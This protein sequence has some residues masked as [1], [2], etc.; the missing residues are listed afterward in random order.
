MSHLLFLTD[1]FHIPVHGLLPSVRYWELQPLPARAPCAVEEAGERCLRGFI[2][3]SLSMDMQWNFPCPSWISIQTEVCWASSAFRCCSLG[4][5]P[6]QHLEE[7][8]PKQ[9]LPRFE[10]FG[11]V[12]F[13]FS[14]SNLPGS[15]LP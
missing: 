2:R 10:V 11:K 8:L 14:Y 15:T 1:S 5:L 13:F 9:C 3:A 4:I 6:V 12:D 7:S